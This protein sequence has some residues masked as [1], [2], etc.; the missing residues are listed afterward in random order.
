MIRK[1]IVNTVLTLVLMAVTLGSCTPA[2]TDDPVLNNTVKTS[3]SMKVTATST[4]Y[5]GKYA[6]NH[7]LAV[8]IETSSG[9]FVKTLLMHAQAR[10]IHLTSWF[11]ATPSGDCTDAVTGATL[12]SHA[13]FNCTW[14]G[15]DVKGNVAGDGNYNVCMEFTEINGSGKVARFPFAKDIASDSQITASKNNF[16]NVSV[17]WTP[18]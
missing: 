3:G 2:S 15:T 17:V 16:T 10:R 11:N 12:N 18:N 8:W 1:G 9:V 7:V 14:D 4:T 5:D 6:P 13:T